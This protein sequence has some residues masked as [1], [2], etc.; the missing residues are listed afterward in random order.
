MKVFVDAN[1]ILDK[2]DEKRPFSR[3]SIL[4]YEYLIIHAEIF[5]SCDLITTIYYV[6]SKE[7]KRQAILNIQAINKTLKVIAFSNKEI[8]ESCK[9]ML[10]DGDYKDLE[11][12][13]QYIMAKNITV[14]L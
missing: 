10:E 14:N 13:I 5:T 4:C 7:D 9:L 1:I 11:D 6:N 3:F 8:E 12:T 2:Y